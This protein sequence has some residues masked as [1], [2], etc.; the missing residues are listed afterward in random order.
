[1]ASPN[2]IASVKKH[3]GFRSKPYVDTTGNITVGWGRNLDANPLSP[4]EAELLFENDLLRAV[5]GAEKFVS[6]FGELDEVRQ[7]TLIE[8]CF[9]L[10]LK[11]LTGFKKFKAAVEA[12][13]FPEAYTQMLDSLWAKQVGYR[14]QVLA[15]QMLTGEWAP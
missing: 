2:L 5:D 8:M 6:N 7:S 13:D 12:K 4:E 10:G 15:Y 9:N 11:K 3:E 1:M 14:S